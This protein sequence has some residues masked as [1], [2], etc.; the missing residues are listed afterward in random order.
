MI[1][2]MLLIA[3][4][5]TFGLDCTDFMDSVKGALGRWLKV[6]PENITL[7]PFDCSLCSTWWACLLYCVI[8]GH[9]GLQGIAAA[10]G[11]ALLTKPLAMLLKNVRYAA[12]TL[13]HL[14]ERMLDRFWK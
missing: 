1:T 11:C 8:T 9:F 13:M 7:K 6:K 3:C 14:L 12:E 10:A 2:D 4:I 5:V